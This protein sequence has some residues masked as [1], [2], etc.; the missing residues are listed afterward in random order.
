MITLQEHLNELDRMVTNHASVA[1]IRSQASF[2][3]REVAVLE[4][5]YASL[6][7]THAKLRATNAD[8]DKQF[9]DMKAEFERKILEMKAR[10]KQELSNWL[11]Q[12]AKDQAE[13]R[14]RHT[15]NHNS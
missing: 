6:A 8:F 5:D 4:A 9:S 10:D 3:A 13:F 12:K 7:E 11:T 2:I 15:L 1:E 14:K